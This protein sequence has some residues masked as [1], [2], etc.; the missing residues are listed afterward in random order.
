MEQLKL[1]DALRVLFGSDSAAAR[2]LGI[3]RQ[4]VSLLRKGNRAEDSTIC[5][6]CAL[7]K[8]APGLSLALHRADLANDPATRA[9]WAEVARQLA[10]TNTTTTNPSPPP[11]P[12]AQGGN[13]PD[14]D[15]TGLNNNPVGI[16][17][18]RVIG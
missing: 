4:A 12:L 5:R 10:A 6:A 2:E 11:A 9:A 17:I 8:I 16:Q 14:D 1:L 3:S 18:M 13:Q 7:L 15:P